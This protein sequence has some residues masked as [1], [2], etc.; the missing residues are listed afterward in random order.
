[1]TL[2]ECTYYKAEL[3]KLRAAGVN[4]VL[5]GEHLMREDDPGSAL[6]KLLG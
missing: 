5:V 2:E 3:E 1:M 4:I 6:R